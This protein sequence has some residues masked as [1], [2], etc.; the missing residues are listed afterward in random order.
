VILACVM[1]RYNF[2]KVGAGEI[3][4][5]EKGNPIVDDKGKCRT[6]SELFNVGDGAQQSEFDTDAY[7]PMLLRQNRTR[8][9]VCGL[10]CTELRPT[11]GSCS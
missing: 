2:I 5:D 10:S 4:L 9:V 7:S 11:L 8:N 6:K 3:E 1:R